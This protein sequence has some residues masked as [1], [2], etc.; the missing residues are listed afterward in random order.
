MAVGMSI[1]I[2]IHTLCRF[3]TTDCGVVLEPLGCNSITVWDSEATTNTYVT[4]I[5][6]TNKLKKTLHIYKAASIEAQASVTS[7]L[8]CIPGFCPVKK[9][10]MT[11]YTISTGR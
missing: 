9:G 5:C 10:R 2:G 11:V 3:C 7:V 8:D 1:W 6:V 4:E